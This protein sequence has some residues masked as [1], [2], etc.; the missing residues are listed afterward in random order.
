MDRW[1]GKNYYTKSKKKPD[2]E[3][4]ISYDHKYWKFLEKTNPEKDEQ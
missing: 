4:H 1:M 2:S 3:S